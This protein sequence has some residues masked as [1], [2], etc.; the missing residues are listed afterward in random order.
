MAA[1]S[2]R[3][4]TEFLDWL[5]D[6]AAEDGTT[7]GAEVRNAI[8]AAIVQAGDAERYGIDVLAEDQT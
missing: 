4:P 7:M 3:L 8:G 2:V 6:R 5:N 1:I